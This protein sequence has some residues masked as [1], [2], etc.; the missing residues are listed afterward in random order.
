MPSYNK[1]LL[2]GNLTRD[3]ELR[4]TPKGTAVVE[5]GL[6]VNRRY[7]VENETKEETVFVDITFWGRQAET[8]NQYC[9]KGRPL[10]VEGRLQ[11]DTWD[12]RQT[13]Q[14]KSRLR[15]VG[16]GFQFLG[17][18]RD[19]GDGEPAGRA[20]PSRAAAGTV[21]TPAAEESSGGFDDEGDAMPF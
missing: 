1:V 12:D 3:P 11:L 19:A 13:G 16:E 5:I 2:M 21:R 14:K 6:A 4:Y 7:Q 20:Q 17:A 18:P 15:V 8:I 9:K 10:F